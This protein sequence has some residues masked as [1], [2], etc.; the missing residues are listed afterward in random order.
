MA[1]KHFEKIERHVALLGICTAIMV[2]FGGLAE[3]VP[4]FARAHQVKPPAGAEPYSPLRLVGFNTYEEN[5]CYLCHSQMVRK[6]GFETQRYGHYTTA[7]PIYYDHPVQWGSTR[8]GPDL[9][10]VGCKY[11]DAWLRQHFM[12]PQSLVPA[13]DMPRFNWLANIKINPKDVQ[14]RMRVLRELGTPYTDAQIAAAP[15]AVAGK[16]KMDALIAY[17]QGLGVDNVPASLKP[18]TPEARSGGQ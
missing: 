1:Y 4:L 12:D 18:G 9:A 2:S 17:I 10:N 5:G 13:S 15:K 7:A 8:T 14:R 16:T 11:S 6:L 3:I